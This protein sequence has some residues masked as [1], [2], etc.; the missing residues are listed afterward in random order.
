M[1][2]GTVPPVP[3]RKHSQLAYE[4]PAGPILRRRP[5]GDL[6][7]MRNGGGFEPGVDPGTFL[8]DQSYRSSMPESIT[9]RPATREA[10]RETSLIPPNP[11]LSIMRPHSPHNARRSFEAAIA[12]F[13]QIP[14]ADDGGVESALL[15][16]E[17]RWE[18]P[19]ADSDDNTGLDERQCTGSG[20]DSQR[21]GQRWLHHHQHILGQSTMSNRRHQTLLGENLAYSQVRGRL[22]PPRPYSDSTAESEESYNS[23]PLLERGL[24]D[25]SMKKPQLSRVISTPA[26]PHSKLSDISSRGTSGFE[27]SH[28]S[29]DVVR[30]T[31][32]LRGIPRGSTMPASTP[33]A[34][35]RM[36]DRFSGLSSDMSVDF[37]DRHEAME[38]QSLGTNSMD[39]FSFGIPPHP[40]AHPPSPPMTI[41]NPRSLVSCATPRSP[42]EFQ[43]QPLTPDPSPRHENGR[44]HIRSIDMQNVSNDVL[45][46]SETGRHNQGPQ[47]DP[48]YYHVPFV[49]SCGSKVLA[50]QMTL[51]EMAALSEVDWRD[52][53]D[54]RLS[55]SS[56]STLS[57]VQFLFEE[58]RRGI[59]L[60]VGR[61][62]LM[63][64]WVLSEIVLTQDIHDR[65]HTITKFI[66]TAAHA[67]RIN[68]YATMVQIIIAL[69]STDCTKLERTW[70]LVPQEE[71]YLFKDME[72]LIQPVRNFHGLRVEMETANLQ[73]GCI[74]FVGRF[75]PLKRRM[76][77]G[78][79]TETGLYV[80]DLTYNAQKPAQITNREG[81]PL[82]NFERYRTTARIVKNLLR[83]IDS[84]TKYHIEPVQGIIERCLWIASLSEEQI[85]AR[86]KQL[87]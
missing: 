15:K 58:E 14:D 51:V 74:P 39:E 34:S 71:K 38:M 79:L 10:R 40:L 7:K 21:D 33:K 61:F 19:E 66:H 18:G 41:P 32:S 50:E 82:V 87:H 80:H 47:T 67:K 9:S 26:A 31:E 84:S 86:S 70:A 8:S 5:G 42:V 35:M 6:R 65:A 30:E 53:V 48:G 45:S 55:T 64:K 83:L 13:A 16:L 37:I 4:K 56:P 81:E 78:K 27:S 68:N 11:H 25:E 36:A 52:L 43:T 85:Q 57:W 77:A 54:M 29:F 49:L 60:V 28:L 2:S 69:S 75:P 59:D 23:I 46:R 62:N 72:S 76:Q 17:G 22:A 3:D 63:A 12:Q 20:V 73:E 24:S 1:G 44:G